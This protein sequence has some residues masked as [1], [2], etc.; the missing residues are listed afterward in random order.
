MK[1]LF[2][3]LA[4]IALLPLAITIAKAYGQADTTVSAAG[5][6]VI[7]LPI[8]DIRLGPV[9]IPS[10]CHD[11]LSAQFDNFTRWEDQVTDTYQINTQALDA[12]I[13]SLERELIMR[14]VVIAHYLRVAGVDSA[15]VDSLSP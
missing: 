5:D 8:W 6:T 10:E 4:L 11:L 2:G 3:T 13:D 15:L 9:P 12:K 1:N 7:Y 14:D